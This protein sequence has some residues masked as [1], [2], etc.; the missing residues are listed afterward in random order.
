MRRMPWVETRRRTQRLPLSSQKR[1]YCR[2]GWKVR[3]VVGEDDR[4]GIVPQRCLDDFARVDGRLGEC[5]AKQLLACNHS[6]LRIEPETH[7][8]F[9]LATGQ[10]QAQIVAH[11]PGRGQRALACDILAHR[12][13][14]E[15]DRSL[16]LRTLGRTETLHAGEIGAE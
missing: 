13:P 5:A 16:E 2:L 6:V 8:D 15:L 3:M 12:A 1:R 11:G 10:R 4:C 14:R 7:E 9:V